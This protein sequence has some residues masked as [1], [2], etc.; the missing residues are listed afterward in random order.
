M[1]W[2][3]TC[4]KLLCGRNKNKS[5]ADSMILIQLGN[6]WSGL[7]RLRGLAGG[8]YW[9]CGR[10]ANFQPGRGKTGC[11]PVPVHVF[12]WGMTTFSW[13]VP[14]LVL[15]HPQH[16]KCSLSR[17]G[18]GESCLGCESAHCKQ[19]IFK[20]LSS[21]LGRCIETSLWVQVLTLTQELVCDV[22]VFPWAPGKDFCLFNV[23]PW[24]FF[25]HQIQFMQLEWSAA[26]CDRIN[27]V[28]LE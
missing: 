8:R 16:S 28:D 26:V 2:D 6:I 7:S 5:T 11:F 13:H 10:L 1:I 9:W 23:L 20:S 3:I 22:A 21:W 14:E 12:W 4:L 18:Q 25:F 19:R 24:S 15:T 27:L 17:V